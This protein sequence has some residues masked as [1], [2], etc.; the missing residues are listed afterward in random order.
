M[1]VIILIVFL[2]YLPYWLILWVKPFLQ[3]S[4]LYY[5]V[6]LVKYH[7]RLRKGFHYNICYLATFSKCLDGVLKKVVVS[8]LTVQWFN[9]QSCHTEDKN[10][11]F[12]ASPNAV[13]RSKSKDW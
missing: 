2:M 8:S 9:Y 6:F 3:I 13:F 11:A 7:S 12:A 10:I 1:Q 5:Y 4:V